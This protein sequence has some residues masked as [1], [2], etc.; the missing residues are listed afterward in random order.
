ML[1]NRNGKKIYQQEETYEK[2]A[3]T[4]TLAD[5]ALFFMELSFVIFYDTYLFS[6]IITSMVCSLVTAI[7]GFFFIVGSR[8]TITVILFGIG[9]FT[10]IIFGIGII[11]AFSLRLQ[12][13][14]VSEDYLCES[15][16]TFIIAV[17]SICTFLNFFCIFVVVKL[18]SIK[19]KI[20]MNVV[21]GG[22]L[23]NRKMDLSANADEWD[24]PNHDVAGEDSKKRKGII[25]KK[26][27]GFYS[28]SD[29]NNG[30]TKEDY[31]I[32]PLYNQHA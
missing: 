13:C 19:D 8:R 15:G 24:V 7:I 18:Y 11:T 10:S 27:Q 30:K 20:L 5:W 9:S 2:I 17:Q 3:F 21:S 28:F 14:T 25:S 29:G 6:L 16:Y 22:I 4:L 1:K 26:E 31:I 12:H 32:S 23:R